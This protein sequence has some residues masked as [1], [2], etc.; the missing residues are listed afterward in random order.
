MSRARSS[1]W[2]TTNKMPPRGFHPADCRDSPRRLCGG[3]VQ[4]AD[5]TA[6]D[7]G[8]MARR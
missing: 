1:L 3:M 4:S 7:A 5:A 8:H 2:I 6:G